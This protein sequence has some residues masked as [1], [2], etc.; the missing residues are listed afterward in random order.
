LFKKYKIH[1]VPIKW[2]GIN[3]VRITPNVYTLTE[4]LDRLVFAIKDYVQ[5]N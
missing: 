3:G 5:S 4:D 1:T 2:E